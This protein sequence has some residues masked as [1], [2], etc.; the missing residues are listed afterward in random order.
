[1]RTAWVASLVLAAA[2]CA[3]P[4]W[5]KKDTAAEQVQTDLREC[6]DA[7]F[8]EANAVPYPYPTMGPAILQ[9]PSER[10]FNVYPTGPF[11]DPEGER[12]MRESRLVGECLRTKGYEQVPA[13]PKKN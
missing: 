1:M 4:Q 7:A 3:S 13:E 5:A 9:P 8:R 11:A 12:F 2:A 6:E 10:R